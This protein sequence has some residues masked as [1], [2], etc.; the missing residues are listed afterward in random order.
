MDIIQFQDTPSEQ[1]IF[2]A[3]YTALLDQGCPSVNSG[4]GCV[5][6]NNG[7]RCGVGWFI[8]DDVY[9]PEMEDAGDV[10]GLVDKYSD[11]EYGDFDGH[12][13]P[14]WFALRVAILQ[15]IQKAHDEP[16]PGSVSVADYSDEMRASWLQGFRHNMTSLAERFSLTDREQ[17]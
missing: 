8:T 9:D 1:E 10:Q 15:A 16:A 11:N 2:D 7:Y 14:G 12:S 3:A 4:G 5:Y 6:R 13:L 17:S